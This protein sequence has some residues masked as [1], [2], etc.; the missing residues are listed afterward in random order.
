MAPVFVDE[1]DILFM[2]EQMRDVAKAGN[3]KGVIWCKDWG[4]TNYDDAMLLAAEGGHV[5]VVCQCKKWGAT[6]FYKAMELA[7]QGDH[8]GIVYLCDKWIRLQHQLK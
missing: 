4:A 6:E 8:S 2:E 5:E 7:S 1:E 3:I